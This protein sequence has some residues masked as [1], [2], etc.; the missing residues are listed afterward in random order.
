MDRINEILAKLT[1]EKGKGNQAKVAR[2]L[3]EKPQTF[4]NYIKGR[5]IPVSLIEKWKEVYGE[6][7]LQLA[8]KPASTIVSKGVSRETNV[9][10]V[11]TGPVKVLPM[12][13][14]EL[15][16]DDNKEFKNEIKNLWD[17]IRFLKGQGVTPHK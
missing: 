3:G 16:Q 12:D 9:D 8:K 5:T 17:M 2:A 14:W 11:I 10:N 7:L 15:L 13:A 4:G 1:L 6:D